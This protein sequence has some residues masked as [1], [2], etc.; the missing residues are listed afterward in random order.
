MAM[1]VAGSG[2]RVNSCLI[3][4]LYMF[5]WREISEFLLA[6]AVVHHQEHVVSQQLYVDMRC[7]AEKAHDI[8]VK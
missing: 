7:P 6:R 2:E 1:V 4:V 8:P 3:N 5:N